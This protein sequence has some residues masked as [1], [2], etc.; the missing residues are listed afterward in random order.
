MIMGERVSGQRPGRDRAAAEQSE[1]QHC[2]PPQPQRHHREPAG[3]TD[4]R[5]QHGAA[6][7]RQDDDRQQD[8][9]GR[10][11]QRAQSRATFA[12]RSGPHTPGQAE[13]RHQPG[14]VPVVERRAQPSERLAR[15]E[16]RGKD[17]EDQRIGADEGGQRGDRADQRRPACGHQAGKRDRAPEN[18]QVGDGSAGLLPRVVRLHRPGD[19][20]AG[21]GRDGEEQG[22]GRAAP[23][24]RPCSPKQHRNRER[25]PDQQQDDLSPGV[26]PLLDTAGGQERDQRKPG[27]ER[28]PSRRVGADAQRQPVP[29]GCRPGSSGRGAFGRRDAR[30]H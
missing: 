7:I 4:D 9:D 24:G 11:G 14:G 10:D 25:D 19:G 5:R 1:R 30:R 18:R 27:D 29:I 21:Q 12:P 17:L 2:G 15:I 20:N 22:Q 16:G 26:G 28:K 8:S 6:G 3:Q 23:G 13:R